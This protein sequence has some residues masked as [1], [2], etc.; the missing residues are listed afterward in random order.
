MFR[1]NLQIYFGEE[2]IKILSY[3][4]VGLSKMC[5]WDLPTLVLTAVTIEVNWQM[6]S[7]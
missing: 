3:I 2:V 1:E 5:L 4:V 6:I 7:S